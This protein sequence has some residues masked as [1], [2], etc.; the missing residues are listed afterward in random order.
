VKVVVAG[1]GKLGLPMAAVFA[2]SGHEVVGVD[3]V[4]PVVDALNE[5][6]VLIEEPGLSELIAAHSERISATIDYAEAI[7]GAEMTFIIVPTPSGDDGAFVNDYVVSALEQI[8]AVLRDNPQPHLVAVTSTVMPGATA[9]VLAPAFAEALGRPIGN[10][11]SLCYSPEFIAL[12][13]VIRDLKNPD[14][15]LIGADDEVE[16]Q[17]LADFYL[18]IGGGRD[19]P[20]Q[21]MNW[22]NAELAKISVNSFVTMKITYANMLAGICEGLPGGDV[23]VVTRAIGLDTRIGRRYLKG[24][25]P[26]GGPC[27]PRDNRALGVAAEA[28]GAPWDLAAATDRMNN[29]LAERIAAVVADA[30]SE[31][32][33]VAVLGLAYKDNTP[34]VEESAGAKVAAALVALGRTVVVHDPIADASHS[35]ILSGISYTQANDVDAAVADAAAVVVVG[36]DPAYDSLPVLGLAD[37]AQVVDCWRRLADASWPTGVGYRAIGRLHTE[38]L[39]GAPGRG[40]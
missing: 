14:F 26:F 32:D 29:G 25:P 38:A 27:F 7:P 18:G 21:V 35:P 28:V 40:I 4:Q 16:G 30:T 36:D 17:R 8:G 20:V 22:A 3:P 24:G 2:E 31:G 5:G 11:V 39:L 33:T 34:V 9:A 23:D 15:V 13:S 19:V 37:G 6:R 1:L 12:G 10:G